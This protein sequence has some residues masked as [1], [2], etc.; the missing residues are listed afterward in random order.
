VTV[1]ARLYIGVLSILEDDEEEKEQFEAVRK[2]N[3]CEHQKGDA[4]AALTASLRDQLL[5][6]V[7]QAREVVDGQKE[8][9]G[10]SPLHK[11]QFQSTRPVWG[12]TPSR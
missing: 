12:A 6:G 10:D 1:A 4:A 5:R 11:N 9:V 8:S 7:H 3:D 2:N